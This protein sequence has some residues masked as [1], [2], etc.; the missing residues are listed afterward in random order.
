MMRACGSR[1]R[2]RESGKHEEL[3]A[4]DGI[5]ARLY[6]LQFGWAG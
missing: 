6:R 1:G 3:I 5:Y 2:L 4:K